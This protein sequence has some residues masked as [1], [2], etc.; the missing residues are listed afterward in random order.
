VPTT[1]QLNA[2]VDAAR[3][4]AFAEIRAKVPAFFASEADGYVTDAELL[5][6]VKA[7]VTAAME[8]K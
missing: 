1:A 4:F 8:S 7:I 2:G 5:A 3:K 6:A